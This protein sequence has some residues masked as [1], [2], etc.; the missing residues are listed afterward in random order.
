MCLYIYIYTPKA[1]LLGKRWKPQQISKRLWLRW[2]WWSFKV[3][4]FVW[5]PFSAIPLPCKEKTKMG[6]RLDHIITADFLNKIFSHVLKWQLDLGTNGA[7]IIRL[8]ILIDRFSTCSPT[9]RV[10]LIL[11]W[12][13]ANASETRLGHHLLCPKFGPCSGEIATDFKIKQRLN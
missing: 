2:S 5:L 12:S 9:P 13:T 1:S 10:A 3:M 4:I 7:C 11:C 8:M 6:W